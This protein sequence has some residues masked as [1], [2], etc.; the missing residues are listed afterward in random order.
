MPAIILWAIGIP[1]LYSLYALDNLFEPELTVNILG[2]QW[3][4]SYDYPNLDMNF[5]SFLLDQEP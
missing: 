3:Y 5:D 2:N 4:W 1:S